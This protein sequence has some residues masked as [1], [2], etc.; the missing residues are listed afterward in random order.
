MYAKRVSGP[1][2]LSCITCRERRKKCDRTHPACNR[3]KASG[4]TCLGYAS[5]NTGSNSPAVVT[6]SAS[7]VQSIGPPDAELPRTDRG[8]NSS[9]IHTH[10]IDVTQ[11]SRPISDTFNIPNVHS[12]TQAAIA[13]PQQPPATSLE[14]LLT[15]NCGDSGSFFDLNLLHNFGSLT[16]T[17]P[18]ETAEY[19]TKESSTKSS[20]ND[21]E[22]ETNSN[23]PAGYDSIWVSCLRSIALARVKEMHPSCTLYIS[24]DTSAVAVEYIT[25]QYGR[26]YN[27]MSLELASQKESFFKFWISVGIT[28]SK[29]A[30][31]SL[32]IGA[33]IYEAVMSNYTTISKQYIKTLDKFERQIASLNRN[34]MPIEELTGWL[35]AAL[36]LFEL[37]FLINSRLAYKTITLAVPIFLDILALES[38][39]WCAPTGDFRTFGPSLH[40]TLVSPQVGL[41]R[42][43]MADVI[44]SLFTGLPQFA[45]WEASFLPELAHLGWEE[46][47]PGCPLIFLLVFS[48]VNAWR[49]RDASVFHD[50]DGWLLCEKQVKEWRPDCCVVDQ[51]QSWQVIGR[52]A[53]QEALRHT[54]LI[55]LYMGM[56]GLKSG[57]HRVQASC[58]Q[59]AQI[60][61]L[62]HA[63][64][65][66]SVHLYFSALVAGICAVNENT[67]C[68]F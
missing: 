44:M 63:N 62:V 35:F 28:L 1:Y 45:P 66:M 31:W 40:S 51:T 58:K 13:S 23:L 52:L 53:I 33:K 4:F 14:Q 29:S 54:T 17:G 65:N 15:G 39:I 43:A 10:R 8:E 9:T 41:G 67:I 48:R 30:F 47:I 64:P 18:A 7:Q 22:I 68:H 19:Q 34:G 59:I 24:P 2:P 25:S 49:H 36:E 57:D 46:W 42:F 16:S 12:Q 27:L 50:P 61:K 3:C 56:C 11:V 21:C 60:C 37:R 55:Y 20:L 26:A 6:G 38:T 5:R 32:F